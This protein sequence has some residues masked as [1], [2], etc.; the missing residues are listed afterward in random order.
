[1][2]NLNISSKSKIIITLLAIAL[3]VSTIITVFTKQKIDYFK[4]SLNYEQNTNSK[5]QEIKFSTKH[6]QELATDILA[7]GE[8]EGLEELKKLKEIFK[9]QLKELISISK[10]SYTKEIENSFEN[11]FDELKKMAQIGIDI[12][13]SRDASHKIMESFDEDNDALKSYIL[14]LKIEELNRYKI[15]YTI[16]ETQ[17]ILTD[18]LA[19]G[20]GADLPEAIELKEHSLKIIKSHNLKE[21]ER[22][23]I[24]MFEDGYKMATFGVAI[25]K[26]YLDAQKQMEIVDS[27]ADSYQ[28][29]IE[30]VSNKKL[31]KL[32]RTVSDLEIL[33]YKIIGN[34]III[35][36]FIAVAGA[37]VTFT[38]RGILNKVE[39]LFKMSKN[40]AS[41]EADLTSRFKIKGSDEIEKT[42]EQINL[43]I[44]KSQN[45][46]ENIKHSSHQNSSLATELA[47]TSSQIA[48][49]IEEKSQLV[50]GIKTN[51]QDNKVAFDSYV[52]ATLK[53]NEEIKKIDGNIQETK[54]KIVSM[55][56]DIHSS[57]DLQSNLAIKLDTLSKDAES[58]KEILSVINDIANQT[59]LLALNATIEAARAG[60]HGR[61]FAVVA[62]NVKNL[63]ERT[64][65]SLVDINA[66]I[67]QIV[68]EIITVS[69]EM[70]ENSK[71]VNNLAEL[72][73]EVESS[74]NE[75]SSLTEGLNTLSNKIV[76][77]SAVV[78]Q[79]SRN[80]LEKISN[81]S[82][83]AHLNARSTEEFHLAIE[84]LHKN[85]EN[86]D[87]QVNMFKS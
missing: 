56:S 62:D 74:L 13:E 71:Q 78:T 61:G 33:E 7:M 50:D 81:L 39:D 48:H 32:N 5:L 63:A 84:D 41:K 35:T 85:I 25:T 17:E 44:K 47:S 15:K 21:L 23:Y 59:D 37:I 34:F 8:R 65:K 11:Y 66:N 79:N 53:A 76:D 38:F 49:R 60:E 57:A 40:L 52:E 12:K 64:Q 83:L 30:K 31:E 67:S 18:I 28:E 2:F 22:L 73:S 6:I 10:E 27:I 29:L 3:I 68:N 58:V 26:G 86:L 9:K 75:T 14:K 16:K 51:S 77:D 54:S 80:R 46:I 36:L 82:E 43:F 20:D 45:C 4:E 19:I 24:K 1:M 42:K 87:N 55:I 69:S 70:S 72:S